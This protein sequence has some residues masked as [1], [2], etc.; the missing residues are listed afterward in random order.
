MVAIGV[1]R[2]SGSTTRETVM[3]LDCGTTKRA[4]AGSGQAR[5]TLTTPLLSAAAAA[6]SG[7]WESE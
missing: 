7:S 3:E 2:E 1:P 4:K 6:A 5:G